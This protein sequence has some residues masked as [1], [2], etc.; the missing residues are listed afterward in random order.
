MM[1]APQRRHRSDTGGLV[2]GLILLVVGGYYLLQ[3]TFGMNLPDLD[4]DRM[5]PVIVIAIGASV[6]YGAWTRRTDA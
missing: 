6:F 5:W 2:F 4:W 1:D 3:E